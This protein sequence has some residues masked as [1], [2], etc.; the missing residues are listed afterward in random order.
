MHSLI[1][2]RYSRRNA[3]E[4]VDSGNSCSRRYTR[5]GVVD[6][7]R[8][9]ENSDSAGIYGRSACFASAREPLAPPVPRVPPALPPD[10]VLESEPTWVRGAAYGG[11]GGVSRISGAEPSG[12]DGSG[13]MRRR[14]NKETNLRLS[15]ALEVR[16]TPLAVINL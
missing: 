1:L 2:F 6:V 9:A 10:A 15:C 12:Y 5:V 3:D 4:G 11:S 13:E 8:S 14:A 7:T 16:G